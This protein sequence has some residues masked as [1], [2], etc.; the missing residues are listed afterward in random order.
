ME[1][2]TRSSTA[3]SCSKVQSRFSVSFKPNARMKNLFLMFMHMPDSFFLF[4]FIFISAIL[5]L[6]SVMSNT[7]ALY[8]RYKKDD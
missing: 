8:R 5:I 3:K 7:T 6:L 2:Y 4:L 1:R